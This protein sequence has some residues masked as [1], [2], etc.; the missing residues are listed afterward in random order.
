[1]DRSFPAENRTSETVKISLSQ[2]FATFGIPKT[3]LSDNGAKFVSGNFEQW[4]EP[5]GIRRRESPVH[6]PRSNGLAEKTVQTVKRAVP[7]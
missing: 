1:M 3:F 7:S 4:C 6:H 2:I 5:Q